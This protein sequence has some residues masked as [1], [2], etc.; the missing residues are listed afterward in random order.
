MLLYREVNIFALGKSDYLSGCVLLIHFQPCGRGCGLHCFDQFLHSAGGLALFSYGENIANL[1]IM[2]GMSA[3][4][5]FR[6]M[7]AWSTS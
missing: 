5:P 2:E 4:L 3:F 7:C 1:R 6:R